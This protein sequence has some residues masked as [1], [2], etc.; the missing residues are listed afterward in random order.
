TDQPADISAYFF[1]AEPSIDL[2]YIRLRLSGAYASGQSD[3]FKNTEHGF[4]AILE[5]PQ[6]AGADASYWIRQSI[7]LIGGG[8]V[9]LTGRNG[10]LPSLRSS[11]TEGQSN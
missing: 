11:K 2:D 8:G 3:P 4:D 9:G 7:P 6:F 10:M 1:A 5:N